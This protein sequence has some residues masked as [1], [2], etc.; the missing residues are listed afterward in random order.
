[1]F[2]YVVRR[3][4]NV[5]FT[6]L[7]IT[8]VT[9]GVFFLVPKLTGSDPALLYIG[10]TA[11]P[12]AVE[13]IRT[14]LGLDDPIHV[15][16]GKFLQGL[17][18]GREYDN[19]PDVTTCNA[20]CFGY[21]FK[22]DQ[23]VWPYLIDRLPVTLSLALG[24]AVLWVIGGIGA[25]VI[26]AL[27]KGRPADRIVMTTALAGVSLPIY[28]TG[29][30]SAAVFSYWLGW[31]PPPGYVDFVVNPA[32]WALNLILPWITLAFLFAAT[33]ARLTR[34]NMLETLSEDYIRTARAKG[35]RER[36]VVSKHAL[37]SGLTPLI[38]VFGLDLGSLLG[39]AILTETT[40]NLRGLG[41]A[42]LTSIRQN[43]LPIILGVTLFAAFFI[44]I[45]NLVV[46]LLYAAVDPRVRLS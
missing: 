6:L 30:V 15:Q 10:K 3:L 38:T 23:E 27:R 24:A 37:R 22:T 42:T 18:M 17:V 20:P 14:K 33:Y 39:G 12:V 41:E 26:S 32:E 44:V 1:M 28:F 46:D 19:G 35:L 29:L 36:D 43:D 34:A 25:G 45:A 8:L 40:F 5:V 31:L 16:Y 13:G 11:D 2:A 9:F 7:V 4:I 21:S